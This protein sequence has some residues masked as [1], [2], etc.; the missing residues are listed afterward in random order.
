MGRQ[1]VNRHLTALRPSDKQPGLVYLMVTSAFFQEYRTGIINM[2][3]RTFVAAFL[4]LLLVSAATYAQNSPSKDFPNIK[5]KNFGQMNERY[6]RGA[7]PK[8]GQRQF[9][10]LKALG[11]ETVID[12]Q[13]DARPYEKREAEAAGLRYINIPM[14]DG[15]YPEA[16]HIEEFLRLA[17]DP[18]TGVFFAH[19]AGGRHRTG[20]TGAAYRMTKYGW[21]LEQAYREMKSYDFYASWLRG[22]QKQK[23]FIEDFAAKLDSERLAST[24]A[25]SRTSK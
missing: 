19:C 22:H 10:A 17:N 12:L 16:A 25:S 24:G 2:F 13:A 8:Q 9:E 21:G 7:R 3:S 5:I 20:I 14:H 1:A 11:V 6:Y 4:T 23:V 15:G 18:E